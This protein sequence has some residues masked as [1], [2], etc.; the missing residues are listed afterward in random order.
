MSDP[1]PQPAP[2]ATRHA[3]L[4]LGGAFAT[5]AVG[6]SMLHAYTVF[7]RVYVE[8]FGWSRGDASIAYAVSQLVSGIGA[9]LVGLAVDRL[10]T[11]RL[12]LVGAGLLGVGLVGSSFATALWQVVILYG[13]VMTMGVNCLGMVV[14]APLLSKL[15]AQRRGMAFSVVQAANGFGR[16]IATPV[17]QLLVSVISWRMA[18]LVQ[19]GVLALLIVP[20]GLLF[21][22][23]DT[24]GRGGEQSPA[25]PPEVT[26]RQWT[27]REAMRTLRFWLLSL[28][29]LCTGLGSFFV[30]L[31]Q[32]A[33]LVDRGFD[34]LYAASVIGIGALL[35]TPGI[36]LTGMLSD[37]I[38][39]EL[40]GGSTYAISIAGV[41][42]ALFIEGPDDHWLLW[43]HACLFGITWGARGPTITAKT[44]DLFPGGNL[45]AIL[46]VIT[47]GS[48]LGAAFGSWGAGVIFDVSGSYRLAFHLSII[49][50]LV[51]AVAFW[52]LRRP[53]D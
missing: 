51:G 3:R 53:A 18:Y 34:P 4:M 28:I 49:S 32:L 44:A 52:V 25:P 22:G 36:I 38:G 21:R 16:A 27:L 17:V 5:F 20:L 29:F 48:G 2:R 37:V 1:S 19:A 26:A 45:G 24:G 46:G 23:A 47:I 10:G 41:V 14:F 7:L 42:C 35:S 50:Y 40:A 39:R 30:S 11:R 8:E 15:F 31:H 9:P 12:V 6:A 33:F 13:V 43:G